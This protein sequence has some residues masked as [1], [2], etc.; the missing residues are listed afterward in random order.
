M[1]PDILVK[2]SSALMSRLLKVGWFKGTECCL[3]RK[4]EGLNNT[5]DCVVAKDSSNGPSL[6]LLASAPLTKMSEF[7]VGAYSH[8]WMFLLTYN[9]RN[10][11]KLSSVRSMNQLRLVLIGNFTVV[12]RP[13]YGFKSNIF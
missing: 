8:F 7:F 4:R 12:N 9:L 3:K 13:Y 5:V 1:N 11:L 10:F 2:P 6:F